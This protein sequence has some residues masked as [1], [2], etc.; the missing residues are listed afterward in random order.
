MKYV[1]A[2][3]SGLWRQAP[4]NPPRDWERTLVMALEHGRW[5]VNRRP[6]DVF[7]GLVVAFDED[8]D[9][10]FFLQSERAGV[11]APEPAR[12]DVL[13]FVDDDIALYFQ[14]IG[15]G[16]VMTDEEV[17]DEVRRRQDAT[18]YEAHPGI[19]QDEPDV[20]DKTPPQNAAAK[21]RKKKGKR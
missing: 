17:Q 20:I 19:M 1:R 16:E 6:V 15:Y 10:Q 21:P 4:F 7:P 9:A 5:A 2:L 12:G 18:A 8:H 13:A 14:S 11:P 3:V